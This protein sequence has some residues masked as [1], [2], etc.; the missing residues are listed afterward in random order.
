MNDPE[1]HIRTAARLSVVAGKDLRAAREA[2]DLAYVQAALWRAKG[3][4]GEAAAALQID[5]VTLNR[6]LARGICH[7]QT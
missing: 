5:R 4:R 3:R 6:I 2:F 7:R 1:T